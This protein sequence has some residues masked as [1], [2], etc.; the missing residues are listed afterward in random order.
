MPPIPEALITADFRV[1]K[2]RLIKM[3]R[4][5]ASTGDLKILDPAKML[6]ESIA[7]EF[8]EV[9]DNL[10]AKLNLKQQGL[11]TAKEQFL[12]STQAASSLQSKIERIK[13]IV[14]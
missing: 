13:R 11:D 5:A 3:I 14:C 1:N 8:Q 6:G 12:Y 7:S 4:T 2:I 9:L 10:K